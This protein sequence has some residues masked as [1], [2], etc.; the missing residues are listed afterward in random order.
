MVDAGAVLVPTLVTYHA[1]KERD[2]EFGLPKATRD[3]N[4]TILDAGLEALEIAHRLGVT[5]G[6]G[7]DLLGETQPMQ[8]RELA[9]RREVEPAAA[10][11]RSMWIT[12]AQLCRLEGRIGLIAPGAF[13]DVVVSQVCPCRRP[14]RVRRRRRFAQPRDPGWPGRRRAVSAFTEHHGQTRH[15]TPSP[16]AAH[17]PKRWPHPPETCRSGKG[18]P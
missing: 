8:P 2:A 11:L 7:T 15:G 13:G 9:I 17:R 10:I 5:M 14:R 1:M 16:A 12:N 3:K 18:C 4:E 6:L